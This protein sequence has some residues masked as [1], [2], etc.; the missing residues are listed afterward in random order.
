MTDTSTRN[1]QGATATLTTDT[2]LTISEIVDLTGRD[3]KTVSEW[4]RTGDRYPKAVQEQSGRSSWRVPVKDLFAAGDLKPSPV[5]E[6]P[7]VMESLRE[8]K[9]VGEMR[10]PVRRA[11]EA[12]EVQAARAE[13]RQVSIATLPALLPALLPTLVPSTPTAVSR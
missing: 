6:V 9:Q 11:R 3:R 7:A 12:L 13:E 2:M 1:A 8:A 4:V 5:M 10:A